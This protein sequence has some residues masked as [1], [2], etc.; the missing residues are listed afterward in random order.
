MTERSL[1]WGCAE[2]DTPLP[3]G[4]EELCQCCS[5]YFCIPCFDQH[6]CDPCSDCGMT[7][8]TEG[9]PAAPE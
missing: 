7:H 5:Q 4:E 1:D 9:C 6:E 3:S 2:C 8:I